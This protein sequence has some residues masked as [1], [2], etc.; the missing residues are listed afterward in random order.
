MKF[1]WYFVNNPETLASC[2]EHFYNPSVSDLVWRIVDTYNEDT[3]NKV[4]MI[5]K[6]L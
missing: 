6:I 3:D 2:I 5:N 4:M 1:Y